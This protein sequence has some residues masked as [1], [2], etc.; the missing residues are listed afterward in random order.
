MANR[1]LICIHCGNSKWLSQSQWRN[2]LE[3]WHTPLK[4][5]RNFECGACKKLRKNLPFEFQLKY[6]IP[7]K[8]LRTKLRS[9]HDDYILHK[10]LPKLQDDFNL[11]LTNHNIEL[12]KVQYILSEDNI[13]VLKM[14][15]TDLPFLDKLEIPI[16]TIR[17]KTN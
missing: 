9:V 12:K 1:N 10:S 16:Y 13:L 14:V 6:G 15:I 11:I 3:K 4:T 17:G 5:K 2:L 7:I 8:K